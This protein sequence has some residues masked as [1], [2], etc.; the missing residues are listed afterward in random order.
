MA[1]QWNDELRIPAIRYGEQLAAHH[2]NV[3]DPADTLS[4]AAKAQA[5]SWAVK[6]VPVKAP[7]GKVPTILLF[8]IG[9]VV[10]IT[11]FVVGD[12]AITP[13]LVLWLGISFVFALSALGV[14][15]SFERN[16]AEA[17]KRRVDA[18][19]VVV[20]TFFATID[21]RRNA[22]RNYT[23]PEPGDSTAA[24]RSRAPAPQPQ[25]YGV[26]PQGAEEIVAV[27]MRYLGEDDAATTQY[28]G[29]G[30]VDVTSLHYIA[31]V[32]HYTGT[33][34][35][36]EVREFAGVAGVDGRRALFFTSGQYARGAIDF[37][38]NAGIALFRYDV[39]HGEL[40]GANLRGTHAMENGL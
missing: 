16:T 23:P 21:E 25:P 2:P 29:D 15:K 17:E 19:Q 36:G 11:G 5:E 38:D 10:F 28:S 4:A 20:R 6:A 33:V 30:G 9:F 7:H 1:E 24:R 37:A 27:W 31:Q 40:V 3:W 32:K 39:H 12:E 22:A 8:C 13:M 14:V 26:S 18:V 34:G 35:V